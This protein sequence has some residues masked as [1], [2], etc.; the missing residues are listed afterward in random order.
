[1]KP[2]SLSAFSAAPPA[3]SDPPQGGFA[4]GSNGT[5]NT[6]N[7]FS[8][9]QPQQSSNSFS[10]GSQPQQPATGGFTFGGAQA[11]QN[12]GFTF[13]GNNN[14]SSMSFPPAG[15]NPFGATNGAPKSN[16]S[17]FQGSI[18][19]IPPSSSQQPAPATNGFSFGSAA[20]SPTLSAQ[21][22]GLSDSE[23]DE[24]TRREPYLNSAQQ[25]RLEE[26]VGTHIPQVSRSYA[27]DKPCTDTS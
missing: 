21:S 17:G 9:S 1:M 6:S 8:F 16:A 5:A 2:P 4:F 14:A 15:S 18:F 22:I 3:S 24:I 23:K 10:F 26:I 7:T 13:G 12:G 20:A 11:Q 27:I 25:Q 19:N